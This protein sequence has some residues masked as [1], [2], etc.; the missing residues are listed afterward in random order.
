MDLDGVKNAVGCYFFAD[1]LVDT[2]FLCTLDDV[3]MRSGLGEV[4]KY[5]ML[6]ADVDNL[7]R[8][9]PFNSN[10]VIASCARYKLQVC[11]QDPFCQN[12]R[13][14]LN[15][16]HTVGH[17]ME[18]SLGLTHG[19]A[20]ANGICYETQLAC[21]LGLVSKQYAQQWTDVV[22][23][24]FEVRPLTQ[25]AIELALQ[26]KKNNG[27]NVGFALPPTFQTVQLSPQTVQKIL[28]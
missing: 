27:G 22:R 14:Q 12:V 8:T 15:F 28:L 1:T 25:N 5:R 4:L 3:Q 2:A 16:G 17:A 18:L 7:C 24:Q 10:E 21:A 6:C 26:D 13:N 11:T 19:E 23:S 9:H 20:V